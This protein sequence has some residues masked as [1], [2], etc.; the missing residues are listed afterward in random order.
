L[1][2]G[3]FPIKRLGGCGNTGVG[4]GTPYDHVLKPRGFLRWQMRLPYRL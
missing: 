3:S 1:V 4:K 2:R